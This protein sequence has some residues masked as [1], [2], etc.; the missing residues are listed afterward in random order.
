MVTNKA[1]H[2][3]EFLRQ[4]SEEFYFSEY[5]SGDSTQSF[6]CIVHDALDDLSQNGEIPFHCNLAIMIVLNLFY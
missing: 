6:K 5:L 4:L 2:T 3:N 1:D